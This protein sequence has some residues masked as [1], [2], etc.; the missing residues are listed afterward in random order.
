MHNRGKF[1][2]YSICGCEVIKFQMFSWQ[3]SIHEMHHFGVFFGPEL[4]QINPILLKILPEVVL[5]DKKTVFEEPLKNSNFSQNGRYSKV[6]KFGPTLSPIYP[7]KTAE[8]RE[9]NKYWDKNSAIRL[10][11]SVNPN[12]KALV[13]FK[14]KIGLLFA[15]FEHFLVKN[16]AWSKVKELKSRWD[17]AHVTDTIPGI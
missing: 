12:P 5:K 14:W 9:N 3:G 4:P 2:L 16:R 11:K 15:L 10:S 6:C 1:H 17:L 7:L 13:L 8:I